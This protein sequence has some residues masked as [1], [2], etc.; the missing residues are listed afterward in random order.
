M[1]RSSRPDPEMVTNISD[2]AWFQ[3]VLAG[4]R[5]RLESAS[6]GSKTE[7]YRENQDF[8]PSKQGTKTA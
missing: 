4:S 5:E 7:W 2:L 3:E 1:S 8:E 6:E